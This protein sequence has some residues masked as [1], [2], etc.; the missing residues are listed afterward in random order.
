[1]NIH[2]FVGF[3]LIF[4]II[5]G[6]HVYIIPDGNRQQTDSGHYDINHL[7]D[8]SLGNCAYLAMLGDE[9]GDLGSP[10]LDYDFGYL[11][12]HV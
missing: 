4:T 2:N 6:D 7:F 12:R 5:T 8:I 11:M 1:M 9:Y 3:N 10:C